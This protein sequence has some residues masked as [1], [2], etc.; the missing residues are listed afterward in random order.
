M[1][2]KDLAQGF[3]I[4]LKIDQNNKLID[5]LFQPNQF[6]LN[7]T[8]AKLLQENLELQ[9]QCPHFFE[10]GYCKFCYKEEQN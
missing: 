10:D 1:V 4:K 3:E 7:N 6:V 5:S 2:E 9:K 8:I